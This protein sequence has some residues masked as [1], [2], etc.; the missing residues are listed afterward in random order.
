MKFCPS[1][2]ATLAVQL[3]RIVRLGGR[4]VDFVDFDGS[5]LKGRFRIAALAVDLGLFIGF[6]ML[7]NVGFVGADR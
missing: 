7:A 5:G 1:H 4:D 6:Q 2:T 3:D